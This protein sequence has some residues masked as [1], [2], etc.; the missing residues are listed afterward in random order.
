IDME[1]DVDRD[2]PRRVRRAQAGGQADDQDDQ[3]PGGREQRGVDA[4]EASPQA[5]G[6][7]GLIPPLGG[8]VRTHEDASG[9]PPGPLPFDHRLEPDHATR[10]RARTSSSS[11]M[12]SPGASG[13]GTLPSTRGGRLRTNRR[14]SGEGR[15]QYSTRSPSGQAAIQWSDAARLIPVLK[16]CGT[17]DRPAA[18]AI[19]ETSRQTVSPPQKAT[20]GWRT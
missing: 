19:L 1:P 16:Q 9:S 5:R 6:P 2:L 12:P 20:S 13:T 17:H 8:M 10:Y 14:I 7:G 15:R 18:W 11:S 3:G 4:S